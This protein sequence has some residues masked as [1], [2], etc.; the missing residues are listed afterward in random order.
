MRAPLAAS[1]L[2]ALT[3]L[4]LGAMVGG[5]QA[6]WSDP[7]V[8]LSFQSDGACIAGP[9][10]NNT[11]TQVRIQWTAYNNDA[12]PGR[13]LQLIVWD[14]SDTSA[15]FAASATNVPTGQLPQQTNTSSVHVSYLAN[16]TDMYFGLYDS[17]D[18]GSIWSTSQAPY[19]GSNV[20]AP[21]NGVSGYKM[22]DMT[23]DPDC[24]GA[25]EIAV[26]GNGTDI[27]DGDASPDAADHTDFG[28]S[29]VGGGTVS[30]TF[31][32]ANSGTDT[33][34]L[35][36]NAASLSGAHAADF[37]ITAQPAASVASGGT[38]SV[39]V[40]FDPSA[41]GTR[42]ATLSIANDDADEAPFDFAI[43]GTG[44]GAPEIAVSGNGTDIADGDGSPD[45][46]DHT[47][48]GA[49]D[50]GGGTVSRTFTIANSGTDTLTL[51]SNAASLSGAHAADFAI[52]AQPA[53]SVASGGTTS[54]TVQFDPSAL[55]TRGAT[56]SIANDDADEAPFDFALSGDG[57]A[58]AEITIVQNIT[59]TDTTVGFTSPTGPL[60]FSLST[61][62]GTAQRTVTGVPPGTHAIAAQDMTAAGYGLVSVSC[63]DG[64][65]SGDIEIRTAT[66]ML[67]AGESVICRFELI[68]TRSVT[69]QMIADYL[70]ARNAMIL[71]NQPDVGRRLDRL[72]GG[73]PGD[74]SAGLEMFGLLPWFPS[75]LSMR[76]SDQRFAYSASARE[77]RS[78]FDKRSDQGIN[79]PDIGKWDIWSQGSFALFSDNTSQNGNFGIVHAGIDY[80]ATPDALIGV[81][82]EVDWMDQYFAATSGMVSGVG[83]MVGPYGTFRLDDNFYIDL[84][85]SWGRSRNTISPFG[86]YTDHFDTTRWMAY[87]ALIGEFKID[88]LT[89]SPKLAVEYISEHQH[90]YTDSLSV[91]IPAQTIAQGR[92]DFTPRL[93]Y[94]FDFEDG[95][96]VS[97]WVEAGLVFAFGDEG[98]FSAGSY[99]ANSRGLSGNLKAG[100]GWRVPS[101]AQLD[102]SAQY[103]GIGSTNDS[104]GWRVGFSVPLN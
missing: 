4:G 54:V 64:N 23:T 78:F 51:G 87:G 58:S 45:A 13:T 30:R 11:G 103:D 9:Y 2:L 80:L 62:S 98:A 50:V 39:T 18:T 48:F 59:G 42:G 72:S 76:M 1:R 19:N 31:T 24:T 49:S 35:G 46:A 21:G 16:G 92:V 97:P 69:S 79:I 94:A 27:A 86:T 55:G 43:Q 57:V 96:V 104:Y 53:A 63:D 60:N 25:P 32:I 8:S 22:I 6:G 67:A 91:A 102:L 74:G 85:A 66:V 20:S 3:A 101:G 83:W 99:A 70:G 65:S 95:N 38:T 33:L 61:V 7:S 41:L 37:A 56:L 90:A 17:W 81:K 40:Q 84:G 36:S 26:S 28:A 88:S 5:A 71:N 77:M 89:V 82:L 47:D 73:T 93:A 12:N 15:G 44:T 68:E 29:D 10:A 75:P 34:T 100:L 14:D 52:T